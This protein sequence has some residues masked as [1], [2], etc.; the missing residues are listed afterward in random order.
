MNWWRRLCN[1]EAL[2]QQL[3][4]ELCF[5]LEERI[6]A[7]RREGLSEAGARRRADQEFGG[8]AQ[9]RKPAAT[10]AAPSGWNPRGR[11]CVMPHGLCA[12]RRRSPRPRSL[13]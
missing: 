4:R 5:H 3:D 12:K 13:P 7:L 8:M 6:A 10:P 11:I 9:S 1:R 2:E